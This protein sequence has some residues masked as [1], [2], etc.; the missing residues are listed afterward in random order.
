[1]RLL[2]ESLRI[3]HFFVAHPADSCAAVGWNY[4]ELEGHSEAEVD[5]VFEQ[6]MRE[7]ESILNGCLEG[8][9]LESPVGRCG[10]NIRQTEVRNA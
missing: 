7:F 4:R 1:L 6:G 8:C 9:L 5:R 10:Q 3:D 2:R